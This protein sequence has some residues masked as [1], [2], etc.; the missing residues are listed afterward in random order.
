MKTKSKN[1]LIVILTLLLIISISIIIYMV[2]K[3]NNTLEEIEGTVTVVSKDY[4]IIEKNDEDYL[5]NGINNEYEI[6]DAVHFE[7][8]AK[9]LDKSESPKTIKIEKEQLIKK[10]DKDNQV[11]N[12]MSIENE[13][14]K[15]PSESDNTNSTESPSSPSKNNPDEEVLE[16]FQELEN[17]FKSGSIKE[18]LKSGFITVIDFLFYDGTIKGHTFKDLSDS[19]K[20]KVLAMAL[21][22]DNKIDTYFPGYKEE[23][24]SKTNKAYTTIKNEIVEAYLNVGAKVCEYN[25]ELCTKAKE[26]FS[27]IKK[28]FGLTWDLIKDIAKD[29]VNNLKKWYEIWSGK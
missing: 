23:I 12:D 22:F 19:A 26:E 14:K 27:N 25:S 17:D 13:D 3:N 21:Y 29:G 24:S 6:G 8:K 7:Y 2:I 9:N 1:L 28:N 10:V 16:Y 20:L 18:S 4:L 11:E 5:I 15:T